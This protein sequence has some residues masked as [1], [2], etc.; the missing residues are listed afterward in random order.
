[1]KRRSLC[2]SSQDR[3]RCAASPDGK[4]RKANT[5][6]STPVAHVG[7]AARRDLAGLLVGRCSTPR[8]RARR[9]T[10][11]RSRRRA[12]C[13][14]S[15]GCSRC[16]GCRR[17]RP[18]RRSPSAR[19]APGGTRAGARPSAMPAGL[20]RRGDRAL[21]VGDRLRERLLD[22]AVLAGL[23]HALGER[24]V[25]R[26]RRREHDGVE[27]GVVEQ[28]VEVGGEARARE[29]RA[30][31][32]RAPRRRRRSTTRA[33]SPA[34]RRSCGPGSGPSSRGRRRRRGSGVVI[35]RASYR[36]ERRDD[37][38]PRRARPRT[39][40]AGAGRGGAQ[41]ARAASGSRPTSGFQPASTVSTHSV[42][43]RSVRQGTP[44]R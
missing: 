31:S 23:E 10:R 9:A 36:R 15:G 30:P 32:A 25:R 34:A 19:D 16:S 4:R 5:T 8:R 33:R 13:R 43:S 21:G 24:G 22:E 17:A 29:G 12:A 14:G 42:V 6:S 2:G 26:H 20:R 18:S 3:C 39:A 41:R 38:L 40:A 11:A 7:L 1:M 44:A 27:L 37:A 35:A 28:V